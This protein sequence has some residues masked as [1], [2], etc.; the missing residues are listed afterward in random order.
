MFKAGGAYLPL[1]PTYPPERLLFMLHDS[2][3]LLLVTRDTFLPLFKDYTGKLVSLDAVAAELDASDPANLPCA[4][5]PG[6][7]AY[8]IYTSGSTGQP[9]G[10]AVAHRQLL[11]RF[12]WMWR[13]HPFS[14]GEV[15]CQKTALGFVDSIWEIF[16]PLLRAVPV[17]IVPD[18]RGQGSSGARSDPVEASRDAN[19]ARPGTAR[20]DP[21]RAPESSKSV[22]FAKNVGEQR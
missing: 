13:A 8:A 16:G 5:R 12:A 1:D 3:A 21:A 15:G 18:A 11:N 2:R 4:T 9:K 22:A 20:R 6:N 17:V 7:L 19:L 14:D 10:V